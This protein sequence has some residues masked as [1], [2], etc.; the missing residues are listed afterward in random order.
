MSSYRSVSIRM[1][2]ISEIFQSRGYNFWSLKY[3]RNIVKTFVTMISQMVILAKPVRGKSLVKM[4]F[5]II[6][7]FEIHWKID[8][9]ISQWHPKQF[10]SVT[11]I[12]FLISYDDKYRID[13]KHIE[14][15][16]WS[17]WK[18]IIDLIEKILQLQ[19][20]TSFSNFRWKKNQFWY[21]T[22]HLSRDVIM[23]TN[24]KS[25]IIYAQ[26]EREKKYVLV[27]IIGWIYNFLQVLCR[28][29]DNRFNDIL[30]N[31]I[32]LSVSWREIY[33]FRRLIFVISKTTFSKHIEQNYVDF[34]MIWW[35]FDS[36]LNIILWR[37]ITLN[38]NYEFSSMSQ[39]ITKEMMYFRQNGLF[40][41]DISFI[42]HFQISKFFKM[43]KERSI[44]TTFMIQWSFESQRWVSVESD[45][46]SSNR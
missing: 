27:K 2:F 13:M 31:S 41:N 12:M 45:I 26:K 21:R 16:I 7:V 36:I 32:F 19:V 23:S 17:N 8:T 29:I 30:I 38:T 10:Y 33:R 6:F 24:D 28:K 42:S 37:S 20:I 14:Y 25:N 3:H 1:L 15:P 22:L 9:I 44:E 11:T 35:S 40:L 5:V 39:V 46:Y 34:N 43:F 18:Q 4:N